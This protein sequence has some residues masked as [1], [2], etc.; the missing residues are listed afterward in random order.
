MID[1]DNYDVDS[2]GQLYYNILKWFFETEMEW[3]ELEE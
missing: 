3:K 2:E 1:W